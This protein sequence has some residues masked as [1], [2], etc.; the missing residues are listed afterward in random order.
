MAITLKKMNW[1][2]SPSAWEDAQAWRERRQASRDK[3]EAAASQASNG[4][5][6]AAVSQ[7]QG[8]AT[9]AAQIAN[10]RVSE[11]ARQKLSA[12]TNSLNLEI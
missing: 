4:L 7:T 5:F 11:S 12:V 3:F 8:L 2:R 9:L 1:L 10:Q 6:G